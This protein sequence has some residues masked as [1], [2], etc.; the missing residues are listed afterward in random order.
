MEDSLA[1]S[2]QRANT[3][4]I[5][6]GFQ[7][8]SNICNHKRLVMQF[9]TLRY[10]LVKVEVG[11]MMELE[12]SSGTVAVNYYQ[13]QQIILDPGLGVPITYDGNA[14]AITVIDPGRTIN[15]PTAG[16]SLGDTYEILITPV[17]TPVSFATINPGAAGSIENYGIGVTV[18]LGAGG[19]NNVGSGI[20]TSNNSRMVKLTCIGGSGGLGVLWGITGLTGGP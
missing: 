1:S 4:Q 9:G 10:L 20:F 15:L 3:L 11:E 13:R 14:G 5:N 12:V 7:V 17:P 19:A 16:V 6:P 18:S 2:S 8:L